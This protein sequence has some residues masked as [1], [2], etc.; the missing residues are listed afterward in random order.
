MYV[1]E[2]RGPKRVLIHAKQGSSCLFLPSPSTISLPVSFFP[3]LPCVRACKRESKEVQH[4]VSSSTS[5]ISSLVYNNYLNKTL[6]GRGLSISHL[7]AVLGCTLRSRECESPVHSHSPPACCTVAWRPF[8]SVQLA[9]LAPL[10]L[11]L[12]MFLLLLWD[13]KTRKRKT[14]RRR[15][16]PLQSLP[17]PMCHTVTKRRASDSCLCLAPGTQQRD[18]KESQGGCV[19]L[20]DSRPRLVKLPERKGWL[21]ALPSNLVQLG[22]GGLNWHRCEPRSCA[23]WDTETSG[24]P[25]ASLLQLLRA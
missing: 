25:N 12:A 20:V 21:C 6:P 16:T 11:H 10:D 3:A 15:R 9:A 18:H 7:V 1:F 13:W 23:A 2:E 19:L 8:C 24:G 4:T 22:I 5:H 14:Q 17:R